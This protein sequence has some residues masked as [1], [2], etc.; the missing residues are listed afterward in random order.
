[1]PLTGR[2]RIV[3]MDR[4]TTDL[5]EPGFIAAHGCGDRLYAQG[6]ADVP[7]KSLEHGRANGDITE[8]RTPVSNRKVDLEVGKAPGRSPAIEGRFKITAIEPAGF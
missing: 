4:G 6:I 5:V 7:T 2:W 1:M 8:P 3:W